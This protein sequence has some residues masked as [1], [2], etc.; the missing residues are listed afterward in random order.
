[1]LVPIN[2]TPAA[3]EMVKSI[4]HKKGVPE[5]YMLRIGIKGGA[6]CLGVNYL[7]GFDQPK[8]GDQ[9]FDLDGIPVLIEKKHTMF[10][11][12][13]TVDYV[14]NEGQSGFTFY[15]KDQNSTDQL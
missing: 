1:M 4:M 8:S 5:G 12:G 2:I 13:M 10:L 15:K 14:T 7:L 9:E 11:L 3:A 6:G